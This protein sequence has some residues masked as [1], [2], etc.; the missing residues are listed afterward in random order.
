M[1]LKIDC[2]GSK[3]KKII[4][5]AFAVMSTL[6]SQG[7]PHVVFGMLQYTDGIPPL[8][9]CIEYNVTLLR[10]DKIINYNPTH[11]SAVECTLT[12]EG[13]FAI[14]TS[15]F[16]A[17][18]GDTIR[19]EFH[20]IC[21]EC[22]VIIDTMII[23]NSNPFQDIGIVELPVCTWIKED[24]IGH[25]AF[26]EDTLEWFTFIDNKNNI[27]SKIE[28]Y[29]VFGRRIGYNERLIRYM[30]KQSGIYI[31]RFYLKDGST[32]H[33]KKIIVN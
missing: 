10:T 2:R 1:C 28:V 20:D 12:T 22:L 21:D 9:D 25:I 6:F 4:L 14:Q 15:A 30:F 13:L 24:N 3:M 19:I 29:D 26:G 16:S 32:R 17:H 31:V 5:I 8:T 11:S 18:A 7:T 23:I 27:V 33:M